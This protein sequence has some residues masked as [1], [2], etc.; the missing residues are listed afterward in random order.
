[1]KTNIIIVLLC[2]V[3]FQSYA[4]SKVQVVYATESD[5][6]VPMSMSSGCR[7]VSAECTGDTGI[8]IPID[9]IEPIIKPS[10]IIELPYPEDP[11]PSDPTLVFKT[12]L[13]RL[14]SSCSNWEEI[15]DNLQLDGY[16]PATNNHIGI[17]PLRGYDR[18]RDVYYAV[19]TLSHKGIWAEYKITLRH[20]DI[21]PYDAWIGNDRPD[22]V[23][24]PTIPSIGSVNAGA[25]S[26]TIPI[27]I[28]DGINGV[29]PNLSLVYNS[30]AG[31]G[32]AGYGWNLSGLSVISVNA[33]NIYY[34]GVVSAPKA[35]NPLLLDGQRI[36][37]D[38][39]RLTLENNR[40]VRIRQNGTIY[41]VDY[42]DGSIAT[43]TPFINGYL[44][45]IATYETPVGN[46]MTYTYGGQYINRIDYGGNKRENTSHYASVRFVYETSPDTHITYMAGQNIGYTK[47]LKT[48]NTYNSLSSKLVKAYTLWYNTGY[49]SQLNHIEINDAL[50]SSLYM[51]YGYGVNKQTLNAYSVEPSTYYKNAN[52]RNTLVYTGKLCNWEKGH[53]IVILPQKKPD[54]KYQ[55][56]EKII[57]HCVNNDIPFQY[58]MT[59]GEDFEHIFVANADETPA[60]EIIKLH[61]K[62]TTTHLVEVCSPNVYGSF[63]KSQFTFYSEN[64]NHPDGYSYLIGNFDGTGLNKICIVPVN[65][66]FSSSMM[67][68]L[69]NQ[70][71]LYLSAQNNPSV[72]RYDKGDI[73]FTADYDGDG[74]T[75]IVH[76]NGS[77]LQVIE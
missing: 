35:G 75:D 26:H 25:Y 9:P 46:Y 20:P 73:L 21:E 57:V 34:D 16:V 52:H 24:Y 11:I 14:S 59:V 51:S 36:I 72:L 13:V 64:A 2:L 12:L 56:N 54:E 45:R 4:Q 63:Y 60:D 33:Q 3:F 28:P 50:A 37:S 61:K 31:F 42:P 23:Y 48:I 6:I 18:D 74:K 5:N 10:R 27:E 67:V 41:Y 76:I 40:T 39:G 69:K 8:P 29:Q 62:S 58:E 22:E 17:K 71:S 15:F 43:Y 77:R 70:S 44:W 53:Q 7:V 68:D 19:Y 47:R 1:M 66:S 49:Y 32:V 38:N 65:G 30:R 55:G